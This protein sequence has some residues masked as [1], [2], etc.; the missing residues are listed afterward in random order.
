MIRLANKISGFSRSPLVQRGYQLGG[1][2][3]RGG[4]QLIQAHH[5]GSVRRGGGGLGQDTEGIRFPALN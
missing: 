1:G 2:G 5:V 3:G 4:L